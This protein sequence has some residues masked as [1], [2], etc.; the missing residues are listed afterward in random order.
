MISRD[1]N[2]AEV[3]K[4]PTLTAYR[5]QPNIRSHLVRATVAKN[6][7]RYPQR[8]IKGMKKCNRANCTAC[9]YAREGKSLLINGSTW[10]LNRKFDCNTY[11]IVYAIF[12]KKENCKQV[13]IGETKRLLKSRLA[14]HCGYIVNKDTTQSTG[15]HFNLPGHS[16]SDLSISVIEQVKKNNLVYRKER[17]EYHIRR[18]NTLH[19]GLN[20]KI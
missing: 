18:F 14:D 7:E 5:R 2:L 16:L 6:K 13:Y 3:F 19:K 11:N 1:R 15:H 12:C 9:P 4:T 20:R 8:D 17:E 10:S